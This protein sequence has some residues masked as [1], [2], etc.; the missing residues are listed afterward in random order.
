MPGWLLSESAAPPLTF[1]FR[2]NQSVCFIVLYYLFET[3]LTGVEGLRTFKEIRAV[4]TPVPVVPNLTYRNYKSFRKVC[5]LLAHCNCEV[6][7]MLCLYSAKLDLL[8]FCAA[9]FLI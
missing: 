2:S 8:H 6:Y 9:G 4:M 1:P 7:Q 5:L 3:I